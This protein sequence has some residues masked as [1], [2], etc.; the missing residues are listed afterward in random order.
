MLWHVRSMAV[1]YTIFRWW[2]EVP[3]IY[4]YI[5][6][7]QSAKLNAQKW[8][9]YTFFE[10]LEASTFF[11]NICWKFGKSITKGIYKYIIRIHWNELYTLFESSV[12][13]SVFIYLLN[14][15]TIAVNTFPAKKSWN[16]INFICDGNFNFFNNCW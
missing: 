6:L 4:I 12:M 8:A 16:N 15:C 5:A 7:K 2:F 3:Y 9:L 10:S 1:W 11:L 14:N 13:C